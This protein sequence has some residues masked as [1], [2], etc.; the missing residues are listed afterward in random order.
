MVSHH[1]LESIIPIVVNTISALL[2]ANNG[3]PDATPLPSFSSPFHLRSSFCISTPSFH[4]CI[5]SRAQNLQ[6]HRNHRHRSWTPIS[7][8]QTLPPNNIPK[9]SLQRSKRSSII[10]P[11]PHAKYNST[12]FQVPRRYKSRRHTISVG[13]VYLHVP[14]HIVDGERNSH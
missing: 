2:T 10:H 6:P 4:P 1:H 13:R 8:I 14:L 3:A 12:R 5:L 9:S 7:L 11:C